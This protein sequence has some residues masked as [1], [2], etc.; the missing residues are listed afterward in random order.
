[1]GIAS[2]FKRGK[3][4]DRFVSLLIKQTEVT[5]QGLQLL[6]A[7]LKNVE[8]Q[9]E[10][11]AVKQMKEKER[12]ADEI[13]RI[14]VDELH[15][16]FVTPLDREDIFMLSLHIDNI[17][18]YAYTTIEE[19]HLLEIEP[20][21]HLLNMTSMIT[22]ATEELLLAMQRLSANPRVTA[23][24]A[25]K[26]KKIHNEVEHLYRTAIGDLF[27]KAKDF[28]QLMVMLRRREVYRHVANMADRADD[29]ADVLGMIVMKII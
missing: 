14:L 4:E 1:M 23:D 22:L 21:D 11:G 2:P 26:A 27:R 16:T 29:A 6:E 18:D 28:K 5:H 12:E 8:R 19:M 24:H 10:D 15:N 20:D 7:W 9:I 13:R 25:S 17:I 3:K